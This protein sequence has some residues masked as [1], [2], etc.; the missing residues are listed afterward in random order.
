MVGLGHGTLSNTASRKRSPR[1][2]H[3]VAQR[4]GAQEARVFFG[5]EQIDQ[6]AGI[7][8]VDML[9]IKF[10]ARIGERRRDA[11]FNSAQCR[12]AVNKPKRAAARRQKQFAIGRRQ[13]IADRA[14]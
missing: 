14:G 4:I 5:A 11:A 10:D 9:R 6:R 8:P 2:I 7:E 1:H 3:A 13:L 12:T